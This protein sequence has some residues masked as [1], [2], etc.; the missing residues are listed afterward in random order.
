[1]TARRTPP[2]DAQD[3]LPERPSGRFEVPARARLELARKGL[4]P[5]AR[6]PSGDDLRPPSGQRRP[7]VFDWPGI[8]AAEYSVAEQDVVYPDLAEACLLA[9]GSPR[10]AQLV[11]EL[12]V[13]HA[14][15]VELGVDLADDVSK[16]FENE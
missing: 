15:K 6:M 4:D 16:E 2:S 10:R 13:R 8:G 14:L 12:A 9:K 11:R 1:M 3:E 5:D 7:R